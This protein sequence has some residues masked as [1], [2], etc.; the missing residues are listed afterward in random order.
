MILVG[1]R[2]NDDNGRNSNSA[3]LFTYDGLTW[4]ESDKLTAADGQTNDYFGAAV[5]F[6]ETGQ[7]LLVGAYRE[8]EAAADAGA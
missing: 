5:T 4:N 3:Y 6:N 1:T 7:T 8:D 2:L